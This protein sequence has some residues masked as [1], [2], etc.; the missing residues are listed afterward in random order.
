MQDSLKSLELSWTKPP[1]YVLAMPGPT[2][3][4]S[5][6]QKF[7]KVAAV[8]VSFMVRSITPDTGWIVRKTG[9]GWLGEK[10][11]L[12]RYRMCWV[13]RCVSPCLRSI[14]T[15]GGAKASYRTR[16]SGLRDSRV[17][18]TVTTLASKKLSW[19]KFIRRHRGCLRAWVADS[20]CYIK[21]NMTGEHQMRIFLEACPTG[22][23]WNNSGTGVAKPP[24]QGPP[25]L[26]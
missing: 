23:A 16:Q 14:N 17:Y 15:P 19:V 3:P 4:N 2:H 25:L 18:Y 22:G 8:Q 21:A 5:V 20:L 24:L 9:G 10:K 13:T 11:I 26:S 6:L 7:K 12:S 1:V